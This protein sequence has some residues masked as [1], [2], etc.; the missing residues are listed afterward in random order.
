MRAP[1]LPVMPDDMASTL[2]GRLGTVEAK[3][4]A[5]DRPLERPLSVT[6]PVV[7][8]CTSNRQSPSTA[9]VAAVIT[10]SSRPT[11]GHPPATAITHMVDDIRS[12]RSGALAGYLVG[13][14]Q[15][16]ACDRL[17]ADPGQQ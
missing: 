9:A 12:G 2:P 1:L 14:G 15:H 10:L 11:P 3:Q 13:G 4:E 5:T 6:P 7:L 16:L 8:T 17:Q